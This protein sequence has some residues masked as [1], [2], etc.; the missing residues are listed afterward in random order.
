M[1]DAKL[2]SETSGLPPN[3]NAG[4]IEKQFILD[5]YHIIT[6]TLT[7]CTIIVQRKFGT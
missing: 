3:V 1:Q 7:V 4:P 6:G 2:R 5:E